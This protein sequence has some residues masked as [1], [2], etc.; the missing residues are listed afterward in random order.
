MKE[1]TKVNIM[2]YLKRYIKY[3]VAIIL[4][5]I[6][7]KLL[8]YKGVGLY[9]GIEEMNFSNILLA[10]IGIVGVIG[11]FFYAIKEI[12]IMTEENKRKKEK[13]NYNK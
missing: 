1:K 3:L 8:T 2:T 9:V 6:S 4:A 5:D 12:T 10:I 13:Q 11:T 7:W